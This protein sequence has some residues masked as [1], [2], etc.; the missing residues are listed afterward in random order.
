MTYQAKVNQIQSGSSFYAN[1]TLIILAGAESPRFDSRSTAS[2]QPCGFLAR[3]WLRSKLAGRTVSV[4]EVKTIKEEPRTVLANVM[5]GN[6][7]VNEEVIKAGWAKCQENK[8]SQFATKNGINSAADLDK[9]IGGERT[10]EEKLYIA[11]LIAKHQLKGLYDAANIAQSEKTKF[12]DMTSKGPELQKFVE[13]NKGKTFTGYIDFI[14]DAD[15]YY[16]QLTNDDVTFYKI[17]ATSFAAQ[18][19]NSE[20]QLKLLN[21]FLQRNCQ[22][23]IVSNPQSNLVACMFTFKTKQEELNLSKFLIEAKVANLIEWMLTGT[24]FAQIFGVTLAEKPKAKKSFVSLE[25]GT[26]YQVQILDVQTSDAVVINVGNTEQKIYLASLQTPKC[27]SMIIEQ[28]G[29]ECR[30]YLRSFFRNEIDMKVEYSRELESMDGQPAQTRIYASLY[31]DGEN[32]AFELIRKGLCKVVKHKMTDTNRAS[33]YP[34]YV[35]LETQ[36]STKRVGVHGAVQACTL[37]DISA[38]NPTELKIRSTTLGNQKATI[39][40]VMTGGKIKL[41]LQ[42][43]FNSA[44]Y[45]VVTV[46]PLCCKVPSAKRGEMF[47]EEALEFFRQYLFQQV[48]VQFLGGVERHTNAFFVILKRQNENINIKILESGLAKYVPQKELAQNILNDLQAAEL[49][50]KAK[51]VGLFG[52]SINELEFNKGSFKKPEKMEVVGLNVLDNGELVF[53]PLNQKP[54]ERD[55]SGETI[56]G[57]VGLICMINYNNKLVRARVVKITEEKSYNVYL[58]DFGKYTQTNKLYKITQDEQDQPVVAINASLA[59]IDHSADFKTEKL[60]ND[61]LGEIEDNFIGKQMQ[62]YLFGTD[63]MGYLQIFVQAKQGELD[64]FETLNSYILEEG[65]AKLK[66]IK[67]GEEY[68]EQMGEFEQIAVSTSRGVWK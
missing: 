60:R 58:V 6:S 61:F 13:A 10:Q 30:Q 50:A 54:V 49:R 26:M 67:G 36:A 4:T 5:I 19:T 59:F 64:L 1:G 56:Q 46:T 28:Y 63:E 65:L 11:H 25:N 18:S 40:H 24:K 27:N 48:D 2:S 34:Q 16:V 15:S 55:V 12:V 52:S 37:N 68:Y 42:N 53:R 57:K 51:K 3:E 35:E 38:L 66:E 45:N 39:E 47:G 22:V 29:V 23:E 8:V 21:D 41:M 20:Q 7:F 17:V 33:D 62:C 32:L 43:S 14:R 31:K 44:Q 9:L